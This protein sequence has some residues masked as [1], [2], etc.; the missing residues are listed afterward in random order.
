MAGEVLQGPVEFVRRADGRIEIKS[1]PPN[2]LMSLEFLNRADPA[3]F[4]VGGREVTLAGQVTYRVVGWDNVQSALI[5]ERVGGG[6]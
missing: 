4:R 5:L 1:A 6:V 3:V 2:T